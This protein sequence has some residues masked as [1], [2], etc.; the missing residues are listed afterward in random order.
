ITPWIT[1]PSATVTANRTETP[2]PVIKGSKRDP[3][4]VLQAKEAQGETNVWVKGYIVGGFSGT[5]I[6]SFTTNL[7]EVKISNIAIA[8]VQNETETAKIMPVE[9]PD[10]SIR[11]TLNLLSNPGNLNKQVLIKGDL[12]TYYS[13]PGLKN[14]K[15][16]QINSE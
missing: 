9:L 12:T 14:P 11:D 2:P 7:S 6:G 10:S 13:A 3:Y 4:T 5:S 8:D 1:P 15:D 16:Y